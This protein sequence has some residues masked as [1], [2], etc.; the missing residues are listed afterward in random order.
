MRLFLKIFLTFLIAM[1]AVITVTLAVTPTLG[2]GSMTARWRRLENGA[3]GV[4]AQTAAEIYE[5][6]GAD[7]LD[8]YLIRVNGIASI[9][10]Y[11]FDRSGE[12]SHLAAPAHAVELARS[13]G[14]SGEIKF[15]L[16]P[17]AMWTVRQVAGP[18]GHEYLLVSEISKLLPAFS[19]SATRV[20]SVCAVAA[21]IC[22]WLA[23][24]VS[25]P[26]VQ[27]RAAALRISEGHFSTRVGKSVGRRRDEI[28]DLGRDFD[29]M[30][31]RLETLVAAQ[32]R[33]LA[34]ISH[35]LRSPLTRLNVALAL[36]RRASGDPAQ[37]ALDRIER[38]AE[39]LNTLIGQLS[40]LSLMESGMIVRRR[41]SV[42]L[43]DLVR[44][45]VDDADFEA[46]SVHSTV[47]L[48]AP[49]DTSDAFTLTGD[50]E[51]LRSA[52]ENVIRNAVRYTPENGQ[53][54]VTLT[55]SQTT[56]PEAFI[57]VRDHGP[58][59]PEPLLKEVFQP[60]Y[61]VDPSRDRQSG[62]VGLGLAITEHAVHLHG[63]RVEAANASDGGLEVAI[64]L[65][66]AAS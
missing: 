17:T 58:G 46:R 1:G 24:H 37:P 51:L 25:R 63:G 42:A 40:M 48:D 41:D 59:I 39:R 18:S 13:G 65:P 33:L 43:G 20:L 36:A 45:V 53:V 5:R 60:F 64:S 31:G 12:V 38:E 2:Q 7:A 50:A 8:A 57:H 22:F 11:L 23:R 26:I 49:P 15:Q 61:R 35:E 21:L 9:H 16:R 56:P 14:S 29:Q 28:G 6:D 54:S 34:D 47:R 66:L 62:G 27:M 32:Q 4:Y 52:I 10:A 55:R 44:E 3:L 19:V 30:A